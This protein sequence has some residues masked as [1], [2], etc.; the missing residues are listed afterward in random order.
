MLHL[1]PKQFLPND[2]YNK[3]HLQSLHPRGI[4]LISFGIRRSGSTFVYQSL[5]DL[6]Q[7]GIIKTHLYYR[8]DFKIKV[9]ATIRDFRDCLTSLCRCYHPKLEQL[10]AN[11]LRKY[12]R[13]IIPSIQALQR[14]QKYHECIILRYED[15]ISNTDLIFDAIE[16]L[17]EIE[18]SSDHRNNICQSHSMEQNKIIAA[19]M[20]NF[21]KFDPC[22]QIHGNHIHDG[23]S[24]WKQYVSDPNIMDHIFGSALKQFN[25]S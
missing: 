12:E 5:C 19:K 15:F 1:L 25:Y 13:M 11:I 6:F 10:S 22:N 17:T 24:K 7:D 23:T 16:A 3:R 21:H 20:K 9:L 2:M 14:Y 18:I 4:R 8:N